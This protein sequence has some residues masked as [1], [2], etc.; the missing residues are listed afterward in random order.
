MS[1]SHV[2]CMMPGECAATRITR[3]LGRFVR[4]RSER[5]CCDTTSSDRWAAVTINRGAETAI[6]AGTATELV[7]ET[8]KREA[9]Y[10]NNRTHNSVAIASPS[11][12]GRRLATVTEVGE[13]E[14]EPLAH[15]LGVL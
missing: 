2:Q 13:V 14:Q 11:R 8:E 12:D 4:C 10:E 3:I 9:L 5:A 15:K 7:N 1:P 6:G